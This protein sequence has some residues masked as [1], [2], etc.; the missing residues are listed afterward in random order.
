MTLAYCQ[1]IS[2]FDTIMQSVIF[3]PKLYT[4]VTV[5]TMT[6]T[7]VRQTSTDGD[8]SEMEIP[9]P[10]EISETNY[11]PEILEALKGVRYIA[12]QF[13]EGDDEVAVSV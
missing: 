6:G 13:K 10:E 12:S 3:Q 7:E 4:Q 9:T 5:R 8:W 11:P 1:S 2:T